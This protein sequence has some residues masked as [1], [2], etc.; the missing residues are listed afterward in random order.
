MASRRG[1]VGLLTWASAGFEEGGVVLLRR[2]VAEETAIAPA[3]LDVS[4]NAT[5]YI[6][7][8][9]RTKR[10]DPLDDYKDYTGGWNI[11]NKHYWAGKFHGSTTD[12]LE[13][14]VHQAN[15]TVDNLRN[16]SN[17]LAAAKAVGVNRVFM[18]AAVQTD[19]DQI[20]RKLN[21]SSNEL[22]SR[23]L[24]N[25]HNIQD[26]LDDVLVALVVA[27]TCVAMDEWVTHPH[28]HTALDDI[29]PCVDYATANE[30]LFRSKE[31]T[32]QLA[33]V[34]NQAI[35][36]VSNVNFPPG[37]QPL[38]YNQSGPLMPTLCNPFIGPNMI[39]R[40]CAPGEVDFDNATQVWNGY[41]CRVSP[42]GICITQGRITPDIYSQLSAAVKV[43]YGLYHYTPFLVRLEDC[44]FV[45]E[46]FFSISK[47]EC[48]GLRRYSKW[49][50]AGLVMVSSAVMFSLIFWV[51]YAR[52]RRHRVYTKRR[53]NYS[54]GQAKRSGVDMGDMS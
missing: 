19:I 53:D 31:A 12:T 18:P 28:L 46:T 29:L 36:N 54:K 38:Y 50:Y 6:L 7:A 22:S 11:S 48:P 17:N 14:V 43:G 37:L 5:P 25:S 42:A 3:P 26:V 49:V 27:D 41:T 40:A 20:Q 10:T 15:L 34:V 45:R 39:D 30:S 21:S 44:S 33:N 2:S 13:Y 9:E 35:T 52:E 4:V 23:T 47:D 51:I 32:F 1:L 8:A 24:D 16:F